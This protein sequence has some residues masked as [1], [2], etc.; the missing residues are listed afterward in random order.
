M[1]PSAC[2]MRRISRL[3]LLSGTSSESWFA[4]AALRMRGNRSPMGS[5][6]TMVYPPSLP[7][8]L[9][10]AGDESLVDHLAEALAADAELPEIA[11]RPP[12][13]GAAVRQ[14]DGGGVTGQLRER[15]VIALLLQLGTDRRVLG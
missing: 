14:A 8:R 11:V 6:M 10:A 9:G 1:K 7:A 2:R 5:E 13:D 4:L 15:L 3:I 12:G